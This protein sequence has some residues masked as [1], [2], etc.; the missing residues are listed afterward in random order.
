MFHPSMK[1]PEVPLIR[2]GVA[3]S[4]AL[5]VFLGIVFVFGALH[6]D[7]MWG[8]GAGIAFGGAAVMLALEIGTWAKG[9][10]FKANKR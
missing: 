1:K 5:L 2:R 4:A 3:E 9:K 8:I 7:K 6:A 10:P